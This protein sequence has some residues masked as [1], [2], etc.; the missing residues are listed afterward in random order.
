MAMSFKA[1][2]LKEGQNR[3][4][5]Q[6]RMVADQLMRDDC[7]TGTSYEH[8]VVHML[9]EHNPSRNEAELLYQAGLSW[10]SAN[11]FKGLIEHPYELS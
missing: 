9:N 7:L 1:W 10:A 3:F 4:N 5:M 2:V 6:M 11:G 8:I